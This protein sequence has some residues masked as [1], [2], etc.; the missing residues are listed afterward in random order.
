MFFAIT[1]MMGTVALVAMAFYM[2]RIKVEVEKVHIAVNSERTAMIDELKK[3]HQVIVALNQDKAD[4]TAEA[5][6]VA[7][8]K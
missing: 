5:V 1:A 6:A 7:K 2:T 8:D 3:M 4:M